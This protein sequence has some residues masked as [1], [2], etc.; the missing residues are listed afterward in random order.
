MTSSRPAKDRLPPPQVPP[1]ER[2]G[3]RYEQAA[4]G[5]DV[6]IDQVSGVLV[7]TQVKTG[8]R[9]WALP[10]YGVPVDPT[11]ETDVQWVFFTSMTFEESGQLQISN[12]RRKSFLVDVKTRTVTPLP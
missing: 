5:R 1:L 4:D 8:E 6:G 11:K 10:V 12:E 3:I 9:L 2:D 7:A